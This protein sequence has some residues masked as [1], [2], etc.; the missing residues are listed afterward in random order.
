MS[1]SPCR[2][3]F[4]LVPRVGMAVG[5]C[6]KAGRPG[7][8][9]FVSGREEAGKANRTPPHRASQPAQGPVTHLDVQAH[10]CRPCW[11]E[12][13]PGVATWVG[14]ALCPGHRLAVRPA[15]ISPESPRQVWLRPAGSPGPDTR[16][17]RSPRLLAA[18]CLAALSFRTCC[19]RWWSS[20][21]LR[22]RPGQAQMRPSKDRRPS[23]CPLSG[24]QP[25][26]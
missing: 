18:P 17:A 13:D 25:A 8:K 26:P 10:G 19:S 9:G 5:L 14:L 11:I 15:G 7:S 22:S 6:L 3:F 12:L 2:L 23:T 4:T 20:S 24:A 21:A 1:S 16:A